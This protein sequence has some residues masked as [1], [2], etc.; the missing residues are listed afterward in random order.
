MILPGIHMRHPPQRPP[1]SPRQ[2]HRRPKGAWRSSSKGGNSS[3]SLF[4]S[5][6]T[7]GEEE[8]GRGLPDHVL[9]PGSGVG[10]ALSISAI[11]VW[12]PPQQSSGERM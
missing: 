2:G 1:T 11:N 12:T 5:S 6:P 10:P 8:I 9:Y 3:S 7:A 4:P